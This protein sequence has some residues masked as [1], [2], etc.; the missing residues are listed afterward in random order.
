ME[1]AMLGLYGSYSHRGFAIDAL[2]ETD[3]FDFDQSIKST[4][5]AALL[6]AGSTSLTNFLVASNVYYRRDFGRYWLEPTAGF[7]YIHSAFGDPSL[8]VGDGEALRLQGGVRVCT[9]LM[10]PIGGCGAYRFSREPI[11]MSW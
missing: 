9:D 3:L 8:G 5:D 1:G 10:T 4:C 6:A 7:R 2:A 11:A